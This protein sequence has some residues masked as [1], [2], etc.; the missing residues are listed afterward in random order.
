MKKTELVKIIREAVKSELKESLPVLLKEQLKSN[1][2]I[3]VRDSKEPVDLVEISK[4]TIT[5]IRKDRKEKTYCKNPKLNQILNETVG[6]IPQEGSSVTGHSIS[7]QKMTN[8]SGQEVDMNSLP[9]HVT[10]ALTR[11]YS[12]LLKKVDEKKQGF[13]S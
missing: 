4:K 12:K 11:D 1:D 7:E 3:E 2:T 5:N 10:S 6:G 13:S 9:S 8:L